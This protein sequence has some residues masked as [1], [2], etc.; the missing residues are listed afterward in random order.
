[1]LSIGSSI[2][3]ALSVPHKVLGQV[4]L[5]KMVTGSVASESHI[6]VWPD[7]IEAGRLTVFLRNLVFRIDQNIEPLPDV[8]FIIAQDQIRLDQVAI[9]I[10]NQ[11]E[12]LLD[13]LVV[14]RFAV[15]TGYR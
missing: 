15:R 10:S 1:M 12:C 13:C 6:T 5:K 14:C 2:A 9:A 4:T 3:F 8:R 7:K 11:A